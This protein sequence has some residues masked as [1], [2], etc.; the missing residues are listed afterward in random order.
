MHCRSEGSGGMDAAEVLVSPFH[1]T[2]RNNTLMFPLQNANYGHRHS[3]T[4]VMFNLKY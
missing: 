1:S 2:L 4:S 3:Y